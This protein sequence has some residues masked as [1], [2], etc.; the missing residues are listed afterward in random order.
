MRRAHL[1]LFA[2][3]LWLAVVLAA[4]YWGGEVEFSRQSG[5]KL[6]QIEPK[7]CEKVRVCTWNLRNYG[8][9]RHFAGGRWREHPK[10]ESERAEIRK[11]LR[12][13]DADILV[14]E[15]VQDESFLMDLRGA[16]HAEGLS[17]KYWGIGA[18]EAPMRVAVLSKIEPV[19]F[20]DK[21]LVTF[22]FDGKVRASP[23]GTLGARF[24]CGGVPW[25]VYGV[26]LK[27][28]FGARK[29]DRNFAPFR[30]AELSA[31]MASIDKTEPI[32][33]CGDFNDSVS[34][35]GKI[36]AELGLSY[37]EQRDN[38]G[39]PYSYFWAKKELWF[40]YDR[41]YANSK[42][43]PFLK[44]PARVFESEKHFASDHRPVFVDLDF[45]SIPK[46]SN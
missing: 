6:S 2:L 9:A 23:R 18:N 31:V 46:T 41:F 28:K 21:S 13:I 45:S 24:V 40:D 26:H 42:M 4:F 32:L 37:I 44:C 27:S 1:K 25:A 12:Q 14:L 15:E 43:V 38:S 36:A 7:V 34:A 5:D 20:V 3:V 29:A 22:A 16:L 39:R 35:L 8:V 10:P 33:L 11:I 17:Y 30:E 19:E